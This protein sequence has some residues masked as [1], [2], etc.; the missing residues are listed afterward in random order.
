MPHLLKQWQDEPSNREIAETLNNSV[1][2]REAVGFN[3]DASETS[4]EADVI[5]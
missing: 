2:Q 1:G 5:T 4:R 3:K